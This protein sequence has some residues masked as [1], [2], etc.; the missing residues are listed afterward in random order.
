MPD[1]LISLCGHAI[2]WSTNGTLYLAILPVDLQNL[3]QEFFSAQIATTATRL[4]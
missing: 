2:F 4:N 3:F 1:I